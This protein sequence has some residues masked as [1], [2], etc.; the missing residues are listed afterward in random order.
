MAFSIAVFT[1]AIKIYQVQENLETW[2]SIYRKKPHE[3]F[4]WNHKAP[5]LII[6]FSLP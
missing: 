1:G 6:S 3:Y 2:F 5:N 4:S